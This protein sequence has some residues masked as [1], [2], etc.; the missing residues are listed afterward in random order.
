MIEV[1]IY[2]KT[3]S[4]QTVVAR[5]D[6]PNLHDAGLLLGRLREHLQ[7]HRFPY[8]GSMIISKVETK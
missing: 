3:S 7:A 2:S 4:G 5:G 6:S 8:V 1:R